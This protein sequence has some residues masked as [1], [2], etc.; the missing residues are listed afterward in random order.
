MPKPSKESKSEH[1]QKLL[2]MVFSVVDEKIYEL[3]TAFIVDDLY[4]REAEVTQIIIMQRGDKYVGERTGE[5]IKISFFKY[6]SDLDKLD[7][8]AKQYITTSIVRY[9]DT[10]FPRKTFS[11]NDI[12]KLVDG[13]LVSFNPIY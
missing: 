5:K 3:M 9:F 1:Q 12:R 10:L 2:E 8:K 7:Y 4:R 13:R 11:A 6:F